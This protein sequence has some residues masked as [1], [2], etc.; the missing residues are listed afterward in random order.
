MISAL[1]IVRKLDHTSA[2]CLGNQLMDHKDQVKNSSTFELRVSYKAPSKERIFLGAGWG[3]AD[4]HGAYL[5]SAAADLQI[6]NWALSQ[7][8]PSELCLVFSMSN[9]ASVEGMMVRARGRFGQ[10]Q[11]MVGKNKLT[12]MR[13]SPIFR[14]P[15]LNFAYIFLEPTFGFHTTDQ[16]SFDTVDLVA[17]DELQLSRCA[18][19]V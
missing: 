17:L 2:S 5:S 16:F 3:P 11:V 12:L 4:I 14:D 8:I 10:T 9:R 13:I 1:L 15:L 6:E 18:R 19:F 7:R